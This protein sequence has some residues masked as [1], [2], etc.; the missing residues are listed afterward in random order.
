MN[1][2]EFVKIAGKTPLGQK[3][4]IKR[5]DKK[6]GSTLYIPPKSKCIAD[7]DSSLFLPI[8]WPLQKMLHT[9]KVSISDP[10]IIILLRYPR[11][12]LDPDKL[13][14]FRHLRLNFQSRYEQARS[15]LGPRYR[16]N[17]ETSYLSGNELVLKMSKNTA[18]EIVLFQMH[19]KQ[20]L[21]YF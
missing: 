19:S 5:E 8:I 1:N 6:T 11:L 18:S 16:E 10:K 7:F 3:R 21:P 12:N 15:Q 2:K 14:S 13:A 17:Q 9:S 20:M 4:Q